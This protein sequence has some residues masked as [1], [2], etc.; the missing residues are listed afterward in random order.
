L[1]IGWIAAVAITLAG[2]VQDTDPYWQ[3]R[4]GLENLDG[5]PLARPDAWSWDPV[6]GLFYPNSPAWNTVLALS[7]R[8]MGYWGL[9]VVTVATIAACL[10][11]VAWLSIRLGAH[12][13]VTVVVLLVTSAGILPVL[14]PRPALAAQVLL[15]LAFALAAWWGD[16]AARLGPW[17]NGAIALVA[18]FGISLAGNWIHL[19]WSTLAIATAAG[20]AVIWLLLDGLRMATRLLLVAAGTIGLVGGVLAGPYGLEVTE[21]SAAVVR[22][23]RDL[24]VEWTS[25][26]SPEFAIRWGPEALLVAATVLLAFVWAVRTVT[27]SGRSDER[28]PLAAALTVVALPYAVAGLALIRFVPVA[29]ATIA[30]VLAAGL[31]VGVRRLAGRTNPVPESAGYVRRRLPE[32]LSARFWRVILWAVLILLAPLAVFAGSRHAE[33]A[34]ANVDAL[35]PTGCRMFGTSIEAASIIL[36]RPDVKV[37][38]DGRADYWGRERLVLADHYL[39]EVD[40]PT[41]VPP[42]TTCVVLMD[43]QSDSG[44]SRLTA[45]LDASPD[46]HRV[47][48]TTGANLW[49]PAR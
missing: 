16:R 31:T 13:V 25:P 44:L 43:D 23:C 29:L 32:W 20:W 9:Y 10:G 5:V 11:L 7:W 12:A 28:L 40:Q 27:R 24:I 46:W 21:R 33:P 19:S 22:A 36:D 1:L 49:L 37:W 48:G 47:P 39:Y 14:S 6:G 30:P 15:L 17:A 18:G 42:G 38:V 8:A 45:A 26:F 4:A 34:T 2:T 3:I 35:L 41:L